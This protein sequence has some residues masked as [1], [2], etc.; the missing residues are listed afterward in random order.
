MI[1][2]AV[3]RGGLRIS[4]TSLEKAS[5][6]VHGELASGRAK[7]LKEAVRRA[8]SKTG[9]EVG[10]L[11]YRYSDAKRIEALPLWL[12]EKVEE[13][14]LLLGEYGVAQRGVMKQLD[15]ASD[16]LDKGWSITAVKRFVP[17]A[18]ETEYKLARHAVTEMAEKK[19]PTEQIVRELTAFGFDSKIL[20]LVLKEKKP[21]T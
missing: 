11:W 7:L 12:K 8:A 15:R 1:R 10:T 4:E 20:K 9:I 16:L 13:T 6:M 5:Q 19:I 17:L 18:P 21:V 2:K 14:R 3:K